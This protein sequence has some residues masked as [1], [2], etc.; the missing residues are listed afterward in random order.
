MN[1]RFFFFFFFDPSAGLC[2]DEVFFFFF[3]WFC[4]QRLDLF[5]R[6]LAVLL[7][8]LEYKYVCYARTH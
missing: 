5:N 1:P 8:V 4:F 6:I 2:T 7:V 3:F